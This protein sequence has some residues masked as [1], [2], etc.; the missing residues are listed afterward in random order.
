MTKG[1]THTAA[2]LFAGGSIKKIVVRNY[3]AY[4]S[5]IRGGG[6]E[7]RASTCSGHFL[8]FVSLSE[9]SFSGSLK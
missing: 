3:T 7:Q 8:F 4:G 5:M 9:A 6:Y 2:A 1:I